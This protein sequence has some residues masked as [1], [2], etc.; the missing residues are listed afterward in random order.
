MTA[1]K[2]VRIVGVPLDKISDEVKTVDMNAYNIASNF[3]AR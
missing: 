2:G 1:L 3:F